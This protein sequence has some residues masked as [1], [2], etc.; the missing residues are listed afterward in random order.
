MDLAVAHGLRTYDALRATLKGVNRFGFGTGSV[1]VRASLEGLDFLKYLPPGLGEPCQQRAKQE[2]RKQRAEERVK[3]AHQAVAEE[4][5][6]RKDAIIA[7]A[8]AKAIAHALEMKRQAEEERYLYVTGHRYREAVTARQKKA[9]ANIEEFAGR[10]S[11]QSIQRVEEA[12]QLDGEAV[13][14]AEENWRKLTELVRDRHGATATT[15]FALNNMA[16][17]L[18]EYHMDEATRQVESQTRP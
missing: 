3:A 5:A 8:E 12:K 17:L 1:T 15:A 10:P 14:Q 16:V 9:A 7:A 6:K 11:A 2:A 4:R 18:F 13:R